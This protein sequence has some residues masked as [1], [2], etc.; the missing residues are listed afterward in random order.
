[1]TVDWGWVSGE[2]RVWWGGDCGPSS[3]CL[4]SF[5]L[6]LVHIIKH[7]RSREAQNTAAFLHFPAGIYIVLS[8]LVVSGEFVS[9]LGVL[10]VLAGTTTSHRALL[11]GKLHFLA[12]SK[13][14]LRHSE[15]TV[16]AVLYTPLP[17]H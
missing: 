12:G 15:T 16:Q 4:T 9:S 13:I 11:P 10:T 8:I 2:R 7:H 6:D 14:L 1:M 3:L 17:V 5:V